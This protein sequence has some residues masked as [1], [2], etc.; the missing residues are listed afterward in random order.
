MSEVFSVPLDPFIEG[1]SVKPMNTTCAM[2]AIID[3]VIAAN[4][5]NVE[6]Y[7]TV[8]TKHL[9]CLQAK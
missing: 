4:P 7:R 3:E 5:G 1:K 6:Q 2:E 8:R 9:T